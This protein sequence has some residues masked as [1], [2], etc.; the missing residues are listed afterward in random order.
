M[1]EHIEHQLRTKGADKQLRTLAGEHA[2]CRRLMTAPGIGP[3]TAVRFVATI[4]EP[5]LTLVLQNATVVAPLSSNNRWQICLDARWASTSCASGG[6]ARNPA[7]LSYPVL[8]SARAEAVIRFSLSVAGPA[9]ERSF[10]CRGSRQPW[11]SCQ[12]V[13][14]QPLALLRIAAAAKK[15]LSL[16]M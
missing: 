6:S 1:P 12:L 11:P 8:E 15:Q 2:V 5:G 10:R 14:D 7:C 9:L 13:A 16:G 4:D 3:V